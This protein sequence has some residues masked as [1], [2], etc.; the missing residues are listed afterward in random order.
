MEGII[1][2]DT[3]K[4]SRI[5]YL[6]VLKG[7]GIVF[8]VF[9][10]ANSMRYGSG[11]LYSFH[12][13]LF[14]FISGLL[15]NPAKYPSFNRFFVSRIKQLYVPYVVFYLLCYLYW[16]MIERS[17]RTIAVSPWDGWLGLFWGS[18]NTH[19]IYPAAVLWFVIG[20]LALELL[21]YAVIKGTKS[22]W[23]RGG[24][25]AALTA[26]GL[27]LAKYKLYVLPFSLN[28]ALLAIPFF[29][30]GYLL[31]K[32]LVESDA[33]C[34]AKKSQVL[35]AL[36]PPVVFT[37]WL[38]PWICDLGKQTD[39]SYLTHPAPH[40]FYTIPFIEIALWLGISL[41]I[42]KNSVLEWLGRNTLPILAFHPPIARILTFAAGLVWGISKTEI[43]GAWGSSILLAAASVICCIPLVYLWNRAYPGII[44][45]I[46]RGEQRP[47]D[48]LS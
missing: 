2:P 33:V 38:Y 14:F 24:L 46:F 13:A 26:I 9:A 32:P 37:I 16:L 34:G 4:G 12:I 20:L 5:H 44:A 30:T 3:G 42:G 18:D 36:I 41:L 22:W 19:W 15:M 21:F 28:N 23:I 40:W 25:L 27:L 8:V 47:K 6:D 11:Y 31:R 10:H 35:L 7:I 1:T 17:H 29:T 39:I 43:H 45:F 48:V